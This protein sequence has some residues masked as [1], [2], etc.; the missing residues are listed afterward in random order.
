MKLTKEECFKALDDIKV[1]GISYCI[2]FCS[3]KD[4]A[5]EKR[6]L[7]FEGLKTIEQLINEYFDNP[8][9]KFEELEKGQWVWDSKTS[10]YVKVFNLFINEK[11]RKIINTYGMDYFRIRFEKGRF[12]RKMIEQ[13]EI[14]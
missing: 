5:I 1:D 4:G 6:K 7:H 14:N 12:Y 10:N 2:D 9:L 3:N 13:D 11:G 8:P